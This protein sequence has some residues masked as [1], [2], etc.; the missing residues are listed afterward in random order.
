MKALFTIILLTTLNLHG[1][2]QIKQNEFVLDTVKG[3]GTELMKFPLDFAPEIDFKG[4]EDIRFAPGWSKKGA[5]DFWTYKFVWMLES[6]PSINAVKLERV[7]SL[8]FNGLMN[9]VGKSK[10][11][12]LNE[13][14][15]T[16][17]SLH[18]LWN[19]P[20]SFSG[21][22]D[23]WDV[24]FTQA[25]VHLNLKV[26]KRYCSQKQKYLL[27]FEFSPQPFKHQI[28]SAMDKIGL[29]EDCRL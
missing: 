22:A 29:I 1:I 12:D 11:M 3:W 9:D 23:I 2:S 5:E 15:T 26:I 6:D 27:I 16:K 17:V 24:F 14:A 21:S 4:V 25:A 28:W 10:R 20:V 19:N 7:L 8:Y 18:E 13:I